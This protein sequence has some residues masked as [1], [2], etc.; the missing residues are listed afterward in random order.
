[1][2]GEAFEFC[3]QSAQPNGAR[4]NLDV[5][6]RLDGAGES[7]GI[8]D[9]AV[10]RRTSGET[11]GAING[12]ATHQGLYA[13]V[14]VTEPFFEPHH[15]LA[16]GGEAEMARFDNAC[17]HRAD[18]DLVQALAFGRKKFVRGRG[19]KCLCRPS[20]RMAQAPTAMVE[21]RHADRAVPWAQDRKD[22]ESRARDES[23]EDAAARRRE[24]CPQD[25][26]G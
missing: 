8:G 6:R 15:R 24:S 23:R 3:H 9:R 12:R 5:K 21:P 10:A 1:M 26:H 18:G 7:K 13:L 20:E 17:V 16:A 2:I 4:W 22:R 11:C 14:G 25:I 19:L